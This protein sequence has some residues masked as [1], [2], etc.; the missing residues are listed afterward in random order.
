MTITNTHSSLIRRM[1]LALPA[2]Y[3]APSGEP[4]STLTRIFA[5]VFNLDHVGMDDEF[6]DLGGDSLLA[7]VLS[8][9]VSEWTG[10]EFPPSLLTEYG[11]A[12]QISSW[13]KSL[14]EASIVDRQPSLQSQIEDKVRAL[15]SDWRGE[16]TSPEA[17]L[18]GHNRTGKERPIFW[19]MQLGA[20]INE[21]A[22]R[23]GPKRPL[24]GMCSG[25]FAM[26]RTKTNTA[27]LARRYIDEILAIE[28]TGPYLLGGNCWGGRVAIEMAR[29]LQASGRDVL[30]LTLLDVSPWYVFG[31]TAYPGKVAFFYG[32][33]SRFN[34]YRR[35]RL[36]ELGWRKLFPQGFQLDLLPADHG[37]YFSDR[38]APILVGKLQS[39]L[40]WAEGSVSTLTPGLRG[41]LP[42]ET[43][44]ASF[45]TAERLTMRAGEEQAVEVEVTNASQVLWPVSAESGIALGNHWLSC[46]GEVLIWGD[47]RT[48][49]KSPVSP[50]DKA[51][52]NLHVRAPSEPG[53]YLL[54]IDLVE[55]GV[56]WFK[57]RGSR[58]AVVPTTV[59]D[60]RRRANWFLPRKTPRSTSPY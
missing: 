1:S 33:H 36:P 51:R 16:R 12:R 57:E 44:R 6:F 39:A 29:Q 58:A 48:L 53:E 13:L 9:R 23:L 54:E 52:L 15:I 4:E 43:Y 10:K 46:Q 56:V 26:T 45:Q 11:S 28:Q 31:G 17:L 41:R 8:M 50:N 42:N 38:V 5:E 59:L 22:L 55:E 32:T 2:P 60:R 37:Q 14:S 40:E 35:F 7:E 25:L 18:L 24:Y 19:C 49:L 3:A 47:G 34:P 27:T 20:E 30:L 21:L